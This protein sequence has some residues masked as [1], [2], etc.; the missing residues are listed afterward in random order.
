MGTGV[1]QAVA[2][3]FPAAAVALV[4]GVPLSH[5]V[6]NAASAAIGGLSEGSI[7][8]W[9]AGL[10]ALAVAL[11]TCAG[12]GVPLGFAASRAPPGP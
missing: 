1:V 2:M 3:T 6:V 5:L 8:L 7:S 12:V 11:V 10:A 9:S 4:G